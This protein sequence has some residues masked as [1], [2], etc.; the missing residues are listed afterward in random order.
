MNR[1]RRS[2]RCTRLRQKA[3]ELNEA[4][5]AATMEELEDAE[6]FK[7]FRILPKSMAADVFSHLSEACQ[8]PIE[9]PSL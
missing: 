6:Q 1:C 2:C 3:A 7:M 8:L 5:I 4:D 9:M